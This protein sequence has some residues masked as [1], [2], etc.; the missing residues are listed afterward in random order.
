M[1]AA[2]A[3]SLQQPHF[4]RTAQELNGS[5]SSNWGSKSIFSLTCGSENS[6]E[7]VESEVV[8]KVDMSDLQGV[9]GVAVIDDPRTL[10]VALRFTQP[11]ILIREESGGDSPFTTRIFSISLYDSYFRLDLGFHYLCFFVVKFPCDR[12]CL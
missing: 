7:K 2:A 6:V 10:S 8:I 9:K 5:S 12:T 4:Q 3:V 11:V 1:K